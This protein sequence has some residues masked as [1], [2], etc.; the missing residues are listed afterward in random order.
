MDTKERG[1]GREG[2]GERGGGGY[3][4]HF[5][6][7]DIVLGLAV[8]V[9]GRLGTATTASDWLLQYLSLPDWSP[10]IVLV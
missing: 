1:E 9:T 2:R 8:S 3:A 7:S 10:E 6:W 4:G 5:D